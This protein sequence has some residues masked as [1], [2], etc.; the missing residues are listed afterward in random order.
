MFI[1]SLLSNLFFVQIMTSILTLKKIQN[2]FKVLSYEET[3]FNKNFL[4]LNKT[5]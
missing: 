1:T 2:L 5:S 3:V 4:N